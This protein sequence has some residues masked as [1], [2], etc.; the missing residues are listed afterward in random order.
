MLDEEVNPEMVDVMAEYM[1]I[2]LQERPKSEV[3]ETRQRFLL[4]LAMNLGKRTWHERL[5][6]WPWRPWRSYGH[7]FDKK[8]IQEW[9]K[10]KQRRADAGW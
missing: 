6:S 4:L 7:W 8:W 3:D 9:K 1:K 10:Y 2:K 5:F